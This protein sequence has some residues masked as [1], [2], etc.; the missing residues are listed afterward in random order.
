MATITSA[1]S[2]EHDAGATWVGGTAPGPTDDVVIA[3]THNVSY[4][5]TTLT[6]NS[7]QV[8]SGGTAT[9]TSSALALTLAGE[10]GSG[11]ALNIAVGSVSG[12][13]D[14]IITTS[15]AATFA[16]GTNKIRNLTVN[17]TGTSTEPD[18]GSITGNL[19]VT[20]T[21]L[22]P[23]G[24]ANTLSVGGNIFVA[25]TATFGRTDWTGNLTVGGNWKNDGTYSH[26]AQTVIFTSKTPRISGTGTTSFSTVQFLKDSVVDGNVTAT[27]NLKASGAGHLKINGSLS[28][29]AAIGTAG[30]NNTILVRG[31]DGMTGAKRCHVKS[32]FAQKNL[33][34]LHHFLVDFAGRKK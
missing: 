33:N 9:I 19:I 2:G 34:L 29:A 3:N 31:S 10:D 28:G 11:R 6:Y 15:T 25:S 16:P 12:V 5:V 14:I 21:W 26:G 18:S 20:K 13:L 4:D 8:Q 24:A 17:A 32:H 27:V 7:F 22:R 30:T 23:S 1:G